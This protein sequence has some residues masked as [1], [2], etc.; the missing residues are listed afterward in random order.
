MSEEK[1]KRKLANAGIALGLVFL[2]GTI[3]ILVE[4]STRVTLGDFRQEVWL[5]VGGIAIA[6]DIQVIYDGLGEYLEKR[7][8]DIPIKFW[9][10]VFI[11]MGMFLILFIWAPIIGL[12]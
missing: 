2:I 4:M 12:W 7:P 8:Y 3:L 5:F 10:G 9:V 6:F 11:D 1:S